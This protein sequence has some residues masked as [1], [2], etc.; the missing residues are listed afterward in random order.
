[1][2]D[3]DDG[4]SRTPLATVQALVSAGYRAAVTI[5]GPYSLAAASRVVSRRVRVPRAASDGYVQAIGRELA[6]REY[7]TVLPTGDEALLALHPSLR[8]LVDKSSLSAV[9]LQAGLEAPPTQTFGSTEELLDAGARLE[10]PVVVKPTLGHPARRVASP[11]ELAAWKGEAGRWIVQPYL[12]ERLRSV[13]GVIWKGRLAACVHQR[14]LRTWPPDCGMACAAETIEPSVELEERLVRL[15]SGF[16]GVFQ[17]D[18]AG[19]YLLDVNP[20]VFASLP[21]AVEAGANLVG[22]YCDLLSGVRASGDDSA[23]VI[24]RG[25]TGVRFRWFD[26]D[27]RHLARQVRHGHMSAGRA[28]RLLVPRK[29]TAHPFRPF[30]DPGP[31]VAR[32]RFGLRR[33]PGR[34]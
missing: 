24:V 21:L 31:V 16:E 7:L 17:A 10:Y 25:R 29:R 23:H 18:V 30:T 15:L 28:L 33:R 6:G 11:S 12:T 32:L 9:A 20:R 3:G 14:F 8:E 4:Q 13:A 1:V 19:R 26:G 2:S 22:V 5:S 34:R 27:V